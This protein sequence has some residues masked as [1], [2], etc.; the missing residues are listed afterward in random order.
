MPTR[1]VSLALTLLL[2][3]E[4]T[5][6]QAAVPG[7]NVI[8]VQTVRDR[9]SVSLGATVVPLTDVT[10]SAQ[11]PGRVEYIAGEEG[12]SFEKGVLLVSLNDDE[13]LAQRR[14]AVATIGN[15]DSALRAAGVQYSRELW[16]PQ[17][18]NGTGGMGIPSMFDQLFT[19]PMAGMM[20]P[21]MGQ[22]SP[23]VERGAD[24]YASGAR[25]EQAQNTLRQAISQLHTLDAKLRDSK[26]LAPMDGVIIKKFVEVGDAVQ[27][28]QP[29]FEFADIEFLQIQVDVP[30]RLMPGIRKGMIVPAKL[31]IGDTRVDV[32][33]AQIFPMADPDRHTVTVKFDL[34]RGSAAAPGMYSE[35]LIPDVN[36]A[37]RELPVVPMSAIRRRGSLPGVYV[38]ND[39]NQPELRLIRVGDKVDRDHISVLSGLRAGERILMTPESGVAPGW[40]PSQP[41]SQK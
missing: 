20:G 25:I 22:P 27:P 21:S 10:L 5:G 6:I 29:M 3:A 17:S 15:A 8:T 1:I 28:G 9:P 35:V 39:Q 30:A 34:P 38:L 41:S 36:A 19:R 12:D 4:A 2:G 40:V 18:W 11:L 33:V 14:A 31:D 24:L 7:P 32:R 13:L 37:A 26:S 16:A 23:W